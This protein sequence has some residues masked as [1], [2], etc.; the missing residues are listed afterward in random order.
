MDRVMIAIQQK[1]AK[2]Y[3]MTLP[4]ILPPSLQTYLPLTPPSL[5]PSL[6]PYPWCYWD[7]SCCAAPCPS[8]LMKGGRE[9]GR[10]G[11]ASSVRK[12][13]KHLEGGKGGW[14]REMKE[15]KKREG[16]REEKAAREEGTKLAT[17]EGGREGG[18]EG[19]TYRSTAGGAW[20]C[21]RCSA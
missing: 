9:G 4:S 8:C 16:R 11:G 15:N 2:G 3:C 5:P 20:S 21:R 6:P 10:E 13:A 7:R 19:G 18:R 1:L 12:E 17:N 14:H